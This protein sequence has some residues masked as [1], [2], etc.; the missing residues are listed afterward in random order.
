MKKKPMRKRYAADEKA[1]IVL[2]ILKENQTLAQIS[3]A[4]G[5]HVNQ[6][7]LWKAQALERFP[8]V[9]S[10]ENQALRDVQAAHEQERTELY[11]EI[12]RLTTQLA[13]LKKKSGL[14]LLPD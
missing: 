13:W 14:H 5:V 12:G 10:D 4:Y 9:F 7:R 11:S 3:A 8:S 1:H 2:E 6:L